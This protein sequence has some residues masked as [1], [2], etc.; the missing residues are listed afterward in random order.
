MLL[1]P[2]TAGAFNRNIDKR[3]ARK[4]VWLRE[5]IPMPHPIP[6]L[7]KAPSYLSHFFTY[8]SLALPTLFTS[9]FFL[10]II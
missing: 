10:I 9:L 1:D 7:N 3:L 2:F 6:F 5:T 8:R 4:L